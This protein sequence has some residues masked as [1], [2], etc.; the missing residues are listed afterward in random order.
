MLEQVREFIGEYRML[1]PG[2]RAVVAVSGGADSVCLLSVLAELAPE[3]LLSLRAVHVHHGLRGAEADRD[4]AYVRELCGSLK[5]PLTVVHRDVAAYAADRGLSTEEAGRIL[6]YEA[7]EEEAAAWDRENGDGREAKIAVAHHRDDNAETILHH[8]LRGSGLKG[9]SGIRPV[10]GRRIRPLLCAGREEILA[11]L[12][13][14][15]ISWCEDSTNASGDYT[16]NRIRG[17]LLPMMKELV[18]GRAAE[19]ILRAGEIFAQADSYLEKQAA[20]VWETAG[21]TSG[22]NSARSAG[23]TYAEIHL[24]SFRQ[25]EEIIQVYLLRRMLDETAPGW[26]DITFRH[27]TGLAKLASCPVGS[28]MDLPCGMEAETGYETLRIGPRQKKLQKNGGPDR[29]IMEM[30][31]FSRE[32]GKEIPKNQYTKWFD[33][34]KIRDV[35][36]VR[37]RQEGDYLLLPG[38]GKKTVARYMIDEKIPRQERDRIPV[39]AEGSHVLWLA[40]YRIS[41]YYKITDNT[42]TV[43]QVTFDGGK[44]HG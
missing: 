30:S 6:R 5:V 19:N 36:S 22:I 13:E 8:L 29:E 16:R 14:K 7:F 1:E 44:N 4:E 27:F 10:Q 34:D 20:Q 12:R 43:L 40:G 24:D 28:R 3:L 21:S 2:E 35:L 9:L 15:K 31:I 23:G 11:Y 26:K 42:E 38:G 37:Y 18:N 33:Y 25:Q 32:K 41:E 17:Q 39:L